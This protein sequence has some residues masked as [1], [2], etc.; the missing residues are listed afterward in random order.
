MERL[1]NFS[2]KRKS[3][4]SQPYIVVSDFENITEKECIKYDRGNQEKYNT[5]LLKAKQA[6]YTIRNSGLSMNLEVPMPPRPCNRDRYILWKKRNISK[7]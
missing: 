1:R 6:Q 5:L 4:N 2:I 3:R 7:I